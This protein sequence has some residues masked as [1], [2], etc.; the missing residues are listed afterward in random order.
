MVSNIVRFDRI[1][2]IQSGDITTSYLG[3][4][5]DYATAHP[6]TQAPFAHMMRVLHFINDTNGILMI[7]FDGVID[8]AVLLPN[9]FALY[10]LTSDQDDNESFRYQMGTEIFA[11]YLLAPTIQTMSTNTLYLV[12]VYGKGE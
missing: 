3:L 4:G 12:D 6:P 9:S 2:G 10:D 8:N 1:R 5:F 7:S 11:K